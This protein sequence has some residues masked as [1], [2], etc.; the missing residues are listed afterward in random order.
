VVLQ[1]PARRG[2]VGRGEGSARRTQAIRTSA[3]A[4]TARWL[5]VPVE[6][7]PDSA[8]RLPQV[9]HSNRGSILDSRISSGCLSADSSIEFAG[10]V[11]AAIQLRSRIPSR[12]DQS[13]TK[14]SQPP[15]SRVEEATGDILNAIK[16]SRI[17]QPILD[18]I[19]RT[20]SRLCVVEFAQISQLQDGKYH[21]AATSNMAKGFG[22]AP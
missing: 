21:P 4:D 11:V 8:Q 15:F 9:A 12:P 13:S 16:R 2:E 17:D 3:L 6:V 5:S 7:G 1:Q 18:T 14:D 22:A 10:L 19:V 20:A